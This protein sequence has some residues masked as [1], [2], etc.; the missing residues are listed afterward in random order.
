MNGVSSKG[1]DGGNVVASDLPL[2]ISSLNDIKTLMTLVNDMIRNIIHRV[3]NKELPIDQGMSFLDVKNQMLLKYL[4]NLN[5]VMLK[6]V[7]GESIKGDPVIDRLVEIRTILERMRPVEHKL[8][9]QI[10]KLLKFAATGKFAEN[11]PLQFKA[12][13]NNLISKVGGD[14]DS[15]DEEVGKKKDSNKA[16]VYV[17]PKLVSMQYDGD[18]TGV[19][20]ASKTT[21]K[22]RRHALSSSALQ[23]LREEYMD[24]PAE[25]VEYSANGNRANLVKERQERQ[26]FEET[27]FTRLPYTRQDRHKSRQQYS[28]TAFANELAGLGSQAEGGAGKRKSGSGGKK[29]GGFKKKKRH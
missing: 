23:G 28:S 22:A 14:N 10:E 9:Y 19:Q 8:K 25:I 29:K 21:E 24:T 18:E 26:E 4:I 3:K 1:N 20:R 6:K 7:S 5:C 12:N 16:G 13:P 11:D 17:P 2:A 27:Y 15:S